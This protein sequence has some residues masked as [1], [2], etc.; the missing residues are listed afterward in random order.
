MDDSYNRN[1]LNTDGKDVRGQIA[2]VRKRI[3]LPQLSKSSLLADN[4][5]SVVEIISYRNGSTHQDEYHASLG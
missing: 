1:G 4:G 2:R 3:L 5:G